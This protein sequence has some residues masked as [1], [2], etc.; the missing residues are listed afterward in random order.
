MFYP[1]T[2][3][4]TH[5]S[6][7]QKPVPKPENTTA[8]TDPSP[9]EIQTRI[10]TCRAC[11]KSVADRTD[12]H[13]LDIRATTQKE[14]ERLQNLLV[15]SKPLADQLSIAGAELEKKEKALKRATAIHAS[16]AKVMEEANTNLTEARCSFTAAEAKLKEITA[17]VEAARDPLPQP[18]P[19]VSSDQLTALSQIAIGR[20]P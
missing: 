1:Q 10:A 4:R 16:A 14:L 20:W 18:P 6:V 3:H 19:V 12:G 9:V 11:L 7:G 13:A 2:P 8:G 17:A 15:S 5:Q